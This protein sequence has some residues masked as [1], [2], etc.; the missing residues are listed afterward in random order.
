MK[1]YDTAISSAKMSEPC[2]IINIYIESSVFP[3]RVKS[4]LENTKYLYFVFI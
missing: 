3:F 4:Y 2:I 1:I